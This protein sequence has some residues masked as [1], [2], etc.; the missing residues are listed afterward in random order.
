LS[1]EP[2]KIEILD[3]EKQF[4]L[5]GCVFYGDPFHS[6]GDW[7]IEN[8]IGLTW[9]RFMKLH[10]LNEAFFGK[11]QLNSNLNYEVHIE[12]EEYK[13]TKKFYI[14][15]GIEAI[16]FE[17]IPLGMFGLNLPPTR[18]AIF[19]F[20]GKKMFQGAKYIW[21]KW[22]PRSTYREAHPF[23]I[24]RYDGTRFFDLDNEESELDY[25]IPIC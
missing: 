3:E 9:Q 13:E 8:E 23:L 7:S 12:P 14:F 18:Y 16:T 19:T 20:K 24:Q 2:K 11:N 15:V 1:I 17:E 5:V 10:K 21:E 22:F 4:L 25:L 6:V